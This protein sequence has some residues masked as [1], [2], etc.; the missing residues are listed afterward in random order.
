MKKTIVM[1]V[2]LLSSIVAFSQIPSAEVQIKNCVAGLRLQINVPMPW[3]MG[4]MKKGTS[5]CFEKVKN[6]I[7]CIGDDPKV[8]GLSVSCYHQGSGTFHGAWP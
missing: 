3:C 8:A 7:V 1:S 5:Y 6:E 4:T 2:L